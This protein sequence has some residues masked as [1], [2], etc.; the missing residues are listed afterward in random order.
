MSD[1]K[2]EISNTKVD[3]RTGKAIVIRTPESMVTPPSEKSI[4][5]IDQVVGKNPPVQS[6]R[7]HPEWAGMQI[8]VTDVTFGDGMIGDKK[9][10]YMMAACFI[11]APGAKATPENFVLLRT[12][13]D[14]VYQRVS[15]AWAQGALP[16]RGTLRLAGR[17][18]LLD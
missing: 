9:T 2:Q 3:P 8:T 11:T 6:L 16:I 18:W 5:P 12:G 7:Y 10:E 13:A 1:A 15:A 4:S 14:N 17:K